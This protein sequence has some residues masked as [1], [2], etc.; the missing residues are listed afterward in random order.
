MPRPYISRVCLINEE[1]GGVEGKSLY[2]KF[3]LDGRV[4]SLSDIRDDHVT[5]KSRCLL[6]EERERRA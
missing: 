4:M 5:G 6:V 3:A 1:G 2:L